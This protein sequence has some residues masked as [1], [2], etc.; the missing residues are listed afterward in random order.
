MSAGEK[1]AA[2]AYLVLLVAL[3]TYV[4]II[5]AKLS[6]LEQELTELSEL[7]RERELPRLEREEASLGR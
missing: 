3:L 4:V 2:A 5:A 6:R 7:A 1:Y